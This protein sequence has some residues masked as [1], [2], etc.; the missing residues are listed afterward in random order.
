VKTKAVPSIEHLSR[1]RLLL[2]W[3]APEEG[4]GFGFWVAPSTYNKLEKT[5]LDLTPWENIHSISIT[6]SLALE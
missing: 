2:Y 4:Q 5:N 1:F 6:K 3:I